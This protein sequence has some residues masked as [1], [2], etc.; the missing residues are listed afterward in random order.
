MSKILLLIIAILCIAVLI[1]CGSLYLINNRMLQMQNDNKVQKNIEEFLPLCYRYFIEGY[2]TETLENIQNPHQIKAMEIILTKYIHLLSDQDVI[3]RIHSYAEKNL[4]VHYKKNLRS[5]RWG[6]RINALYKILD[7]QMQSLAPDVLELLNSS[8]EFSQKEYFEMYKVIA[9]L[10]PEQL[11]KPL[12]SSTNRISNTE[13]YNVLVLL[14]ED[15]IKEIMQTFVSLTQN[16][17]IAVIDTIGS[18]SLLECRD[19]LHQAIKDENIEIRL[20][21]LKAILEI[22]FVQSI[23]VYEPFFYADDWR[24]RM[25]FAK[26]LKYFLL[27]EIMDYLKVL[28][29]DRS[30]WVRYHTV[31]MI[32][33]QKNGEKVLKVLYRQTEDPYAKEIIL[34][35]LGA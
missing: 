19:F 31:Q 1:I 26:L 20:H 27:D 32:A 7:F 28:I 11:M 23:E 5:R 30:W 3:I 6:I 2:P 15:S 34:E 35:S 10:M 21:A 18:K 9:L 29:S 4:Y 33:D 24:E 16:Q 25:L 22:G 8:R 14:E 13:L 12:K 17:K